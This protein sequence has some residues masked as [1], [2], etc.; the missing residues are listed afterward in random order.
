MLRFTFCFFLVPS[1]LF[2]NINLKNAKKA[3]SR[4]NYNLA[5]EFFEKVKL[6]NPQNGDV[7]FFIG[8]IY[9]RQK[10]FDEAI[11]MYKKA[12]DLKLREKIELTVIF[13]L[14][15]IIRN[16]PCGKR[17]LITVLSYWK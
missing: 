8:Q 16:L 11:N 3:Y 2:S 17:Y 15:C 6:R 4:K 1:F 5:I 9:M 7:Y 12:L 13:R 10:K 14:S